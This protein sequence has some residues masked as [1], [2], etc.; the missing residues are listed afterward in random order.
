MLEH[1]SRPY[2][3]TLSAPIQYKGLLYTMPPKIVSDELQMLLDH[4][5]W[6]LLTCIPEFYA[7]GDLLSVDG[8]LEQLF[9]IQYQLTLT[10]NLDK[11]TRGEKLRAFNAK[12]PRK[13]QTYQLYP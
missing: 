1:L 9:D 11:K 10:A 2:R 3:K 6:L 7:N 8:C 13:T 12:I 5:Q 4:R